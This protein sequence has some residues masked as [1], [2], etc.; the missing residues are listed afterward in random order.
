MP[1]SI[2][3]DGYLIRQLIVPFRAALIRDGEDRSILNRSV[4]DY[5]DCNMLRNVAKQ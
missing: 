5:T 2:I 4:C 1:K 3:L